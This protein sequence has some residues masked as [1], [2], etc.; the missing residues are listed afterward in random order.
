MLRLFSFGGGVQSTAC[1]VLAAQRKI[2]YPLFVFANVGNNAESP[3][4]LAYIKEQ[5]M[6]FAKAH[7]IELSVVSK[8]GKDGK[9]IDLYDY[10][11]SEKNR[12]IPLP[13]YLQ[14]GAPG[15]RMC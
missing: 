1:L 2:D 3:E 14:S 13:V 5:A 15:T 4:T 12:T 11:V 9:V 10:A 6:P 7:G 8:V